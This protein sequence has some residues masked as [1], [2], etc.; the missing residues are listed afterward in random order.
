MVIVIVYLR[1][2]KQLPEKSWVGEKNNFPY[3]IYILVV[4]GIPIYLYICKKG[5]TFFGQMLGN[6]YSIS[7]LS[8]PEG[9]FV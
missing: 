6:S 7:K 3:Y 4:Y 2:S 1:I 8:I 9:F 5:S